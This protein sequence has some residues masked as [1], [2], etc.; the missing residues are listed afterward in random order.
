MVTCRT[1]D[2]ISD[3]IIYIKV[4]NGL[5]PSYLSELL[6]TYVPMRMLRSSEQLL[7]LEPK[8]NL[9]TYGS[10]AFS[11]CAPRRWSSLP[12][13]IRRSE[14]VTLLTLLRGNLRHFFLRVHFFVSYEYIFK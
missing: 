7:L 11:V 12:L 8:F 2:N 13:E 4:V 5:A 1:E 14:S 9:K 6:Q 10:R 3:F